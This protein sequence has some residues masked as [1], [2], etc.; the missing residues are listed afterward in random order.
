MYSLF[1]EE[2]EDSVKELCNSQWIV[3]ITPDVVGCYFCDG[4]DIERNM[5]AMTSCHTKTK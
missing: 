3:C 2:L 1:T 4:R 5:T